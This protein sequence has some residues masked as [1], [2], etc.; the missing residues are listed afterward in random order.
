MNRMCKKPLFSTFFKLKNTLD[1][2]GSQLI[3][4]G[5]SF[6]IVSSFFFPLPLQTSIATTRKE[7]GLI[8]NRINKIGI[9]MYKK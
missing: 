9:I 7:N 5:E 1:P 8:F 4:K 3:H 6:W 2:G